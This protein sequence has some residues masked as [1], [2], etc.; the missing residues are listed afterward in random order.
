MDERWAEPAAR[1]RNQP[2]FHHPAARG[3]GGLTPPLGAAIGGHEQLLRS[4]ASYEQL[5]AEHE[6]KLADFK[7]DPMAHD[8]EGRLRNAPSDEIRQKIIE[9][10]A[11]ALEGQLA[12]QR[13]ELAKI[14]KHLGDSQ[15]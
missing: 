10:R 14:K 11:K 3:N 15:K 12:K 5:I 7:A 6:Q 9:G 8:N 4:E 1:T 13:G 2:A